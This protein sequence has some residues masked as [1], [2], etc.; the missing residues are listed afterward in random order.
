[1][2]IAVVHA[3]TNDIADWTQADLNQQIALGNFPSGTILAD[4]VLP[5]DW[6]D[7]HIITGLAAVATTGDYSDLIGLPGSNTQVLFND[8]SILAGAAGF[9]FNKTTAVATLTGG[10]VLSNLTAGS[11]LFAGTAGIIQQDNA[12]FFW[13]DT[14]NQLG[15]LTKTP[16]SAFQI[17]G[18]T[19]G[20][21]GTSLQFSSNGSLINFY[22]GSTIRGYI[23]HSGGIEIQNNVAGNEIYLGVNT[24]RVLTVSQTTQHVLVN[25][26]T[27][28]VKGLVVKGAASQTANLLE[29]Q[30]SSGTAYLTVGPPTLTGS[31]ATSNWLNLTATMPTTMSAITYGVNYQITS[32]G[33]SSLNNA[34]VNLD[35]L[36]GYT[37]SSL[38]SGLR[39]VS[40]VAG[41]NTVFSNG[42][43]G[44]R[45]GSRATTTGTNA[46]FQGDAEGG[47]LNYGGQGT[48][49]VDK[50][51]ATNIG[52]AGF[53]LNTGTS[54]VHIAGYFGLQTSTPTFASAALMSDNG[55]T[56][57]DIFVARD[58]G[59]AIFK[60]IDGGHTIVG[61]GTTASELRFL[62]PSGS[63]TN[64][65]AFKAQAQAGDLT[66]TLPA[67]YPA[68]NDYALCSSTSGTLTWNAT[69]PLDA[70][71][72]A[73]AALT[74]AADS[75]TIGT[76]AD[77]F[78]QTSFA[79]N[80][81]PAKASAGNLVAKTI[82]DFGLSLVDDANAAAGRAT[83]SAATTTQ[84]FA[85][86][87]KVG[88]VADGDYD[89]VIKIPF[90]GTITEAV[91]K[92]TTGT[93]TATFKVNT[94]ALGGTANSVSTSENAQTHSSSNTFVADDDI[95]VTISSNSAC[96]NIAF[97]LKYTRS[98]N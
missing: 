15:L 8:G 10:L 76:G 18:G 33:S 7:E 2:V 25:S 21:T 3:K 93:C 49:I 60:V 40:N 26:F 32:A 67:A 37:G 38:T 55:A 81:F 34:A 86:T 31:A 35:Y 92:C 77:A 12:N 89:L 29:A 71:L 45:A 91:T 74:I 75:L 43:S 5:S 90:G 82:T 41:T 72:T 73:F 94:T 57:S 78:S 46:G 16:K 30:N 97:T 48:A 63:G 87:G 47:N 59:L 50:N 11:V 22:N 51:S 96:A 69:Q 64:Y 13:D 79:A 27:A 23:A 28:S 52:I 85:I 9:T 62:E 58:N 61:G 17:G 68:G 20:V 39:I 44:I 98:L 88:T 6:N 53:A 66:Y 24:G 70:T 4:I 95:R 1:M 19:D 65:T 14:N 56:V 84:A 36:S 83:L 42:N 54:P 80:T